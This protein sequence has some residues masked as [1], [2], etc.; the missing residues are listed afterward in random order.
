MNTRITMTTIMRKGTAMDKELGF[1]HILQSV[2]AFFPIGAF[3]L[4]NGLESYVTEGWITSPETLQEYLQGFLY[5]FPYQ[6][7]GLLQL[8][9][10]HA[11]DPA[12]IA[13]LDA[14]AGA[15]KLPREVRQ[16]S[17]RMGKRL[18]KALEKMEVLSPALQEYREGYHPIVLGLYG[19]SWGIDCR[20]LLM[21]YGYGVISAVVNN[22]VKLVPLSQLEGQR[23]L[24]ECLPLLQKAVE[25]AMEVSIE[26]LGISAAANDIHC[27]RHE[28]LYSRQYMS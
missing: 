14:V 18:R 26:E 9:F 12:Y 15:M 21:M 22:A 8:A 7:L 6:D 17:Q 11:E 24:H 27:M 20:Q 2:D 13:E 16:G 25:T 28:R 3:T 23:V 4:S 10:T 19:R 1:L 5:A